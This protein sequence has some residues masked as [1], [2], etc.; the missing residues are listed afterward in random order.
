MFAWTVI[1]EGQYRPPSTFDV[2]IV[3]SVLLELPYGGVL[4]LGNYNTKITVDAFM[5]ADIRQQDRL[6]IVILLFEIHEA[7]QDHLFLALE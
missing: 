7:Q 4:N 6:N 2:P 5:F 1:C 3:P